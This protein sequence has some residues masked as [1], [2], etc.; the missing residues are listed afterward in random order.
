MASARVI[1]EFTIDSTNKAIVLDAGAGDVTATIAEGSYYWSLDDEAD[2]FAKV[3]KT[4]LDAATSKTFTV[5]IVA[6]DVSNPTLSD[7]RIKLSINTGDFT[8][9]LDD[10]ATTLDPRVIG[11]SEDSSNPTSASSLLYS[12]YNHRYG[13]YPQVQVY[14]AD[15]PRATVTASQ[16]TTTGGYIDSVFWVSLDSARWRFEY[17]AAALASAA[18]GTSSTRADRV[19][20]EPEDPNAAFDIFFGDI[21]EGGR[22][23]RFYIEQDSYTADDYDGPYNLVLGG[24]TQHDTLA[25]ANRPMPGGADLFNIDLPGLAVPDS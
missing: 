25:N 22:P 13:F 19:N 1:S 12:D 6:V 15:V 7:G 3:L 20:L 9:K 18:C 14:D 10:A 16:E 21:I 5:N 4:A 24:G 17:V 2:D 8:L 23:W 11:W